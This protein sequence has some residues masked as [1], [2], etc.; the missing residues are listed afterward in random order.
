MFGMKE[1][2]GRYLMEKKNKLELEKEN[3]MIL[4]E[5]ISSSY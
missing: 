5:I 2:D 4:D 3:L 1:P